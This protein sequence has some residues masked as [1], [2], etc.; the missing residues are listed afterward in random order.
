[1]S[2][3]DNRKEKKE[4]KTNPVIR[5]LRIEF[6]ITMMSIVVLFLLAIFGFQYISSKRTMES[7]SRVALTRALNTT[8]FPWEISVFQFEFPGSPDRP[9]DSSE[10]GSTE[11]PPDLPE[12]DGRDSKGERDGQGGQGGRGG[13][14]IEGYRLSEVTDQQDRV[15]ILVAYYA[16]DGTITIARNNIF[17]IDTS[18]VSSIMTTAIAK[19]E[20]D[21]TIDDHNLRFMKK[22]LN[23]GTTVVAFA[24]VSSERSILNAELIRSV[25][26]S[27]GVIVVMF[28]LSFWLSRITTRP[29]ER[30]WNDQRRFVADAS[31]ELKTPLTVIMSNTDMVERSLQE[32][33]DETESDT[34]ETTISVR[35]LQRNLHRMD[36]VK[37]ESLRMKELIGELLEVAR[38]DVGQHPENF[39]DLSLSE[40]A[41]DALLSWESVFFEAGKTLTGDIDP[42]LTINGDRTLLRRLIEILLDNALKYSKEKSEITFSLKKEKAHGG[43][44]QIHLSVANEGTPL[45]Q[46]ELSHLFDRFYRADSSREKTSGYGLGLSIA[47]SIVEAHHGRIWA[48]PTADGNAF[49]IAF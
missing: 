24:D 16:A 43:R 19:R 2:D 7:D 39:V 23:D 46:E 30:A 41:E 8:I 36:N 5:R 35:K 18:D 42:N 20:D 29:V 31:H 14:R 3:K 40:I 27:L 49:H 25:W 34:E 37:E 26:I 32:L 22:R 10:S 15:A 12:N 47:E 45:T 4:K 9:E 1:M 48:E 11:T 21:G 13:G 6:I 33:V 17:F 28:I 44:R 38:G